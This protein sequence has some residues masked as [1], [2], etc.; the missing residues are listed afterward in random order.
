[1]RIEP[2]EAGT[3]ARR[4]AFTQP[5]EPALEVADPS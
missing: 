3:A 2:A 4:F 5:G 1:M